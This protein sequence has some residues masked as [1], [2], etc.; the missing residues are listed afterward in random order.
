MF[1]QFS[2]YVEIYFLRLTVSPAACDLSRPRREHLNGLGHFYRRL[3]PTL[4]NI[5]PWLTVY[6][7]ALAHMSVFLGEAAVGFSSV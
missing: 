1:L 2:R 6:H 7:L 3:S 4:H 5:L